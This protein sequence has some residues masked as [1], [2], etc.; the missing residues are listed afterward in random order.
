MLA[1]CLTACPPACLPANSLPSYLLRA[2]YLQIPFAGSLHVTSARVCF[3]FD[4]RGVAPVKLPGKAIKSV[5]K[6]PQNKQQ[7]ESAG[8]LAA[9]RR[10]KGIACLRWG[11]VHAGQAQRGRCVAGWHTCRE[12]GRQEGT[13]RP[14]GANSC[15]GC[16]MPRQRTLMP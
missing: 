4:E 15:G 16:N 5:A 7:G 2:P 11:Y 8:Q 1:R 6:R 12:A 10:N 3:T 13:Q 14:A 9:S